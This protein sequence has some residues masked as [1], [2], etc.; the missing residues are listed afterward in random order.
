[1]RL[2]PG[3]LLLLVACGHPTL[4]TTESLDGSDGAARQT[5]R[6]IANEVELHYVDQGEGTPLV[7]IHG[8]L[9]DFSY[10]ERSGQLSRLA[11]HHRV[12]AYSRRYNHPNRNDQQAGH[13]PFVEAEDLAAFL[14]ALGLERVHLLGHSYG[15]YTALAFALDHPS[16][17][18]R[19][20]LAEPPIITWLPDVPGGEGIF[21]GFMARVWAPLG[22]AFKD[23]GDAGGLDFTARWYFRV[24]WDEV[25]SDWQTWFSNNVMEWHALAVSPHTFPKLDYDRVCALSVPTLLL[26]GE[27]SAGGFNGLI[28]DHLERLLPQPERFMVSDAGH[29]MFLDAPQHSAE[30]VLSFLRERYETD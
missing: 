16:R 15:A 14:D 18:D 30:A 9:T 21:E 1:M 3:L 27:R 11:A 29:E 8:S 13:S 6:V 2:W 24:P 4:P 20:I 22:E 28:D 25:E 26:S 10:W 5:H 7:L 17:V 12:I 23:G 19:L